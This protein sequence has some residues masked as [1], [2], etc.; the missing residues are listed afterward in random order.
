MVDPEAKIAAFWKKVR[1]WL[2]N[3]LL[4]LLPGLEKLR[5][6]APRR[7]VHHSHRVANQFTLSSHKPLIQ[8]HLR[9][10]QHYH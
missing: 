2:F 8:Y 5:N 3:E 4:L 9:R 10:C 1:W 7:H 6:E